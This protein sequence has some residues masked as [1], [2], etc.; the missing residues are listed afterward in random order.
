VYGQ[1]YVLDT[2]VAIGH[3][4]PYLQVLVTLVFGKPLGSEG[5]AAFMQGF[6]CQWAEKREP[7]NGEQARPFTLLR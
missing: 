2:A 1:G 7:E 3:D 4:T 6:M 5:V